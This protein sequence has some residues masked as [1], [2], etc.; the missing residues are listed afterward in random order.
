MF[1]RTMKTYGFLF[2]TLFINLG[3]QA[4]AQENTNPHELLGDVA[5]ATFEAI[6][7]QQEQIKDD[8]ATLRT[9]MEQELLPHID[10]QYAALKVL[11]KNFRKVPREKLP[12][13]F[14]A[15]KEHLI[16]TYAIALSQYDDQEVIIE[17]SKFKADQKIVTVK[18]IIRDEER[19]DIN[20]SFKV[21]KIR[22]TGE[23]KAFDMI[24]E[25]ISLLSSKQS[26]LEG[27]LRKDGIDG[28]I[29]VLNEKNAQPI[30]LEENDDV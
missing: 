1:N 12:T 26:E 6:K 4:V 22:K 18:A 27:V 29:K 21:R 25:G 7:Q 24:V 2:L 5:K 16:T 17:P 23:W 9:I 19:P 10:F 14:A 30:S 20:I 13:Y 28:V 11:G 8:P 15:F 3:F